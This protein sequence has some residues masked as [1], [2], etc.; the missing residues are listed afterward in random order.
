MVEDRASRFGSSVPRRAR[1]PDAALAPDSRAHTWLFGRAPR[2][3]EPADR[4]A[5]G[6]RPRAANAPAHLTHVVGG[7]ARFACPPPVDPPPAV[8][9]SALAPGPAD[10]RHVRPARDRVDLTIGRAL[11]V[12]AAMSM[13]PCTP[14]ASHAGAPAVRPS[15]S[16]RSTAR[17]R[18]PLGSPRRMPS[19]AHGN[20]WW[21]ATTAHDSEWALCRPM[22]PVQ[23]I[24]PQPHQG[25]FRSLT[26]ESARESRDMSN[27]SG[28]D[29]D[30][31]DVPEAGG[32][33]RMLRAAGRFRK[34]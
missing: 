6:L 5:L 24:V 3:A 2:G 31:D 23:T 7:D 21:P 30:G 20:G 12:S 26:T 25:I 14:P 13:A 17:T 22:G 9:P 27:G 29:D 16:R 15:A 32:C 8:A 18:C 19:Q 33:Q 28:G 1:T 10:R 4:I 11:G 34:R